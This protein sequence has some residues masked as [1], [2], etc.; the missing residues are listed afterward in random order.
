MSGQGDGGG[1][2]Q[3]H[4]AEG[5]RVARRWSLAGMLGEDLEV[6]WYLGISSPHLCSSL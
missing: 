3:L 4:R 6:R 5:C 1:G 2:G